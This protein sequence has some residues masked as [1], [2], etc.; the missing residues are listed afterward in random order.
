MFWGTLPN[1]QPTPYRFTV[2]WDKQEHYFNT[3]THAK[4]FLATEI[5]WLAEDSGDDQAFLAWEKVRKWEVPNAR[6][7]W[8]RMKYEVKVGNPPATYKIRPEFL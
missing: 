2:S 3:F 8:S 6:Q 5:W 7:T 4:D 1:N